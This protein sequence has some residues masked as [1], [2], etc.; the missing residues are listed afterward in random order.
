VVKKYLKNFDFEWNS[1]RNSRNAYT[2]TYTDFRVPRM[3]READG[4]LHK[5]YVTLR[6]PVTTVEPDPYR[7]G[8]FWE[9]D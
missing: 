3:E 7:P 2:T 1:N 6:R 4:S 9:A 5:V 8:R